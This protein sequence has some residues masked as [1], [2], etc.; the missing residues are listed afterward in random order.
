MQT[1]T[2]MA[3]ARPKTAEEPLA[4]RFLCAI[5][6]FPDSR[7]TFKKPIFTIFPGPSS[8]PRRRSPTPRCQKITEHTA[9]KVGVPAN[10]VE[11]VPTISSRLADSIFIDSC[12]I[13]K[14][15]F[16]FFCCAEP[17]VVMT[18]LIP[19]TVVLCADTHG[20]SGSSTQNRRRSTR[21]EISSRHTQF[22]RLP[23]HL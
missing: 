5:H 7:S 9:A 16:R 4:K 20:Y 14:I 13:F 19:N 11:N 17:M 18:D 22:P 8:E 3:E 23:F 10:Y 6:H 21:Q 2:A 12:Y 1:P 15:H